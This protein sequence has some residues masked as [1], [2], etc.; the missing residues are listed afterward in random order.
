MLLNI[1]LI[2]AIS[3]SKDMVLI[4]ILI[5]SIFIEGDFIY[6]YQNLDPLFGH[7]LTDMCGGAKRYHDLQ[8]ISKAFFIYYD[9]LFNLKYWPLWAGSLGSWSKQTWILY[10]L[11]N[12]NFESFGS[13]SFFANF[14]KR[15][16]YNIS[17]F[18]I[19]LFVKGELVLYLNKI[20][21]HSPIGSLCSDW[22]KLVQ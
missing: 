13:T 1:S 9:Q 20:K 16:P 15:T 10:N 14:W 7:Y 21:S 2:V 22:L 17:S 19:N 18:S 5:S 4:F 11:E 6:I 12:F 3:Y 8:N